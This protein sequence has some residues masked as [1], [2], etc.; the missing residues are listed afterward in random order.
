MTAGHFPPLF[1]FRSLRRA[2]TKSRYLLTVCPSNS[3]CRDLPAD[4]GRNR[5][6]DLFLPEVKHDQ[7]RRMHH[8]RRR[9]QMAVPDLFDCRRGFRQLR[10]PLVADKPGNSLSDDSSHHPEDEEQ[11]QQAGHWLPPFRFPSGPERF[12]QFC[13]SFCIS[14]PAVCR[15]C[16]S[17]FRAICSSSSLLRCSCSRME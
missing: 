5:T 12:F 11:K 15:G 4:P 10:R 14:S 13:V 1:F 17:P 9:V 8:V 2:E 7:Q 6:A 3:N 16:M